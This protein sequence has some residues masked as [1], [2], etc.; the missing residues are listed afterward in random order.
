MPQHK[1]EIAADL[2][3]RVSSTY[4]ALSQMSS[5]VGVSVAY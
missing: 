5:S 2:H 1:V 3:E 4:E